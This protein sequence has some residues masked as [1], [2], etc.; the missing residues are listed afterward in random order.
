MHHSNSSYSIRD[1]I[2]EELSVLEPLIA[3][4]VTITSYTWPIGCEILLAVHDLMFKFKF[5]LSTQYP[6]TIPEMSIFEVSSDIS[7]KLLER[8]RSIAHSH[9]GSPMLFALLYEARS[10]LETKTPDKTLLSPH[11]KLSSERL[12]TKQEQSRVFS[13]RRTLLS[14]LKP[15]SSPPSPI[16]ASPLPQST[17]TPTVPSIP[18]S[19]APLPSTSLTSADR[20]L[21]SFTP[22]VSHIQSHYQTF[23]EQ[24][25]ELGRGGGGRVVKCR[26]KIDG[27]TYAIKQVLMARESDVNEAVK[28]AVALSKIHSNHVVSYFH[29][30]K[31]PLSKLD[32]ETVTA[33]TS[34]DKSPG[35]SYD[36]TVDDSRTVNNQSSLIESESFR[37]EVSIKSGLRRSMSYI[38]HRVSRSETLS[39]TLLCSAVDSAES[40]YDTESDQFEFS[41]QLSNNLSDD[42]DDFIVFEDDT[43]Q[44]SP[45][46]S[47]LSSLETP[48]QLPDPEEP[49]VLLIQME[50]CDDTL[51]DAIQRQ[52]DTETFF[53]DAT[54]L[55]LFKE[56]ILGLVDIHCNSLLVHRDIKPANILIQRNTEKRRGSVGSQSI[57]IDSDSDVYDD[58]IGSCKIGDFGLTVSEKHQL[59]CSDGG[60]GGTALYM[61]PELRSSN[62]SEIDF[63][64]TKLDIYAAGI[65]LFEIYF[66]C[67]T[68]SE[69]IFLLNNLYETELPASLTQNYPRIAELIRKMTHKDPAKRPSAQE[70]FNDF[71]SNIPIKTLLGQIEQ[72]KDPEV[73]SKI[74]QI[75]MLKSSIP[76]SNQTV[77]TVKPISYYS[78]LG[79]VL[80]TMTTMLELFGAMYVPLPNPDVTKFGTILPKKFCYLSWFISSAIETGLNSPIYETFKVV[81]ENVQHFYLTYTELVPYESSSFRERV[82]LFC[83]FLQLLSFALYSDLLE[84]SRINLPQINFSTTV[85]ESLP[86]ASCLEESFNNYKSIVELGGELPKDH[87]IVSIFC[88]TLIQLGLGQILKY[89]PYF[90]QKNN[91]NLV[92]FSVECST[93]FAGGL[94]KRKFNNSYYYYV[95]F[96]IDVNLLM[97]L[98]RKLIGEEIPPAFA[99]V[100]R[101]NASN[102]ALVAPQVKVATHLRSMG[103]CVHSPLSQG[104]LDCKKAKIVVTVTND[105][106]EGGKGLEVVISNKN[107]KIYKNRNVKFSKLIDIIKDHVFSP[108]D[109]QPGIINS[110]RRSLHG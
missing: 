27:N 66:P 46:T 8:L 98:R 42:F 39:S 102:L 79:E 89:D 20:K 25:C 3:F 68:Q 93:Y 1:D 26:N 58:D 47:P 62:L 29:T 10:Y 103:L 86:P 109:H 30:W 87:D 72:I 88:S 43:T 82:L 104:D 75:L 64:S 96:E 23:F 34:L 24:I 100:L 81:K 54:K 7:A 99:I 17:H 41:P 15:A 52:L 14:S 80:R 35:C 95:G 65:V 56:I 6:N 76:S 22:E 94:F 71:F 32:K 44:T 9:L 11:S 77:S 53:S 49:M 97:E 59:F 63:Y 38:T 2:R 92:D 108:R 110:R 5:L 83:S 61:A 101:K 36:S 21:M 70:I 31:E 84:N 55:R 60:H 48:S 74:N 37:S 16:P 105:N 13:A 69:R 51:K 85:F 106:V 28:E 4:K 19:S 50:F 33:L 67:V 91:Q 57:L 45:K 107:K 73:L 18:C 90:S 40:E 12:L 78:T